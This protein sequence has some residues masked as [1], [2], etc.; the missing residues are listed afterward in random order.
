VE[1]SGCVANMQ[2]V[3]EGERGHI[4]EYEDYMNWTKVRN[5]SKATAS[6]P[7]LAIII[8]DFIIHHS[9]LRFIRVRTVQETTWANAHHACTEYSE[10]MNEN[11]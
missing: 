10:V 5:Y 3:V 6:S 1:N 9:Q 7:K 11:L 8:S 4:A 2:A